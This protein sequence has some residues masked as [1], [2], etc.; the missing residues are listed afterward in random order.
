MSQAT[1]LVLLPQ[2]AYTGTATM[3]VVGTA[4]KA[5]SYDVAWRDIQTISWSAT[6]SF[7]G[8]AK[9]QVS[10]AETPTALDWADMYTLPTEA[11]SLPGNQSGFYN[12]RGSFVWVRVNV[13]G[14]N[15]GTIQSITM[16]Y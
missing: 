16:S 11:T 4:Q 3:S 6:K 10:L 7:D 13:T 8:V 5:A 9:I 2:T 12:L 14:W 1:S 15:A